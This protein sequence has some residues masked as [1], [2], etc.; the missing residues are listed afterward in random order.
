LQLGPIKAKEHFSYQDHIMTK[1]S[2]QENLGRYPAF[3]TGE[4]NLQGKD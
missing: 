4:I 1:T 3:E 2:S